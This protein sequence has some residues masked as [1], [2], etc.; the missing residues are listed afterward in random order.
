MLDK[1]PATNSDWRQS[2]PPDGTIAP[3]TPGR[4]LCFVVEY[5]SATSGNPIVVEQLSGGPGL[6]NPLIESKPRAR[7]PGELVDQAGSVLNRNQSET[8]LVLGRIGSERDS[9]LRDV[10]GIEMARQMATREDRS[11]PT[12]ENR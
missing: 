3:G 6:V 5:Q 2:T 12:V 11:Q 10:R 8:R 1:F 7:P 4:N 9:H